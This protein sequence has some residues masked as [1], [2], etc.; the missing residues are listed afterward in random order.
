M[1]GTMST[2]SGG[3]LPRRARLRRRHAWR[4]LALGVLLLPFLSIFG[5]A[6]LGGSLVIVQTLAR[7]V[8]P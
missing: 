3:G 8:T 1:I 6:L 7:L 5:G 4:Y 2:L